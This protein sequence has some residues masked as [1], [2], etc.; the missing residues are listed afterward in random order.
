MEV[1]TGGEYYRDRDRVRDEAV[2]GERLL[3]Q[4]EV[5]TQSLGRPLTLLERLQL[6]Y[7]QDPRAQARQLLLDQQP[8]RKKPGRRRR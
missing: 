2:A 5:Q 7:A 1:M 8:R 6:V 3:S 4:L